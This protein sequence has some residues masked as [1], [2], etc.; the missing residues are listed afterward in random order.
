M[1]GK[2]LTYLY[3]IKYNEIDTCHSDLQK[4]VSYFRK[5]KDINSIN[6]LYTGSHKAFPMHYGLQGKI[7]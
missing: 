6:I 2:I 4:H 7:F 1:N 5:K 3:Y